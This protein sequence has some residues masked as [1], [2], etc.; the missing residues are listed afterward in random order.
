MKRVR[1]LYQL[2]TDYIKKC[3]DDHVGAFGAMCSF[4]VI[5]SVFP[6]MIFLL[7][8]TRFLPYSKEDIVRILVNAISFD[9]HLVRRIVNEIY[10]KVGT[11]ISLISILSALWAASSGVYAILLGLNSVFDI[12]ETRN[13]FV[14]RLVSMFYTVIV[15]VLMA[16][17]LVFW[18]FGNAL[19]KYICDKWPFLESM[20]GHILHK[21]LMLTV[22]ILIFLFMMIYQFVPN[23]QSRF[24]QQFPGAVI[25][26]IGWVAVSWFY[27]AF[28]DN[29]K[30]FNYIYGSMAGIMLLFLWLYICMSMV[31]YGA[32][33]NYFFENKKNYHKLVRILRPNWDQQ[34]RRREQEI[35]KTETLSGKTNSEEFL[36][37]LERRVEENKKK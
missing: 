29:M 25:A 32:E 36:K 35:Q 15:V 24:I 10:G 28:V 5:L 26:T 12:D 6:I 33:V 18:V 8:L 22:V 21:R 13:Y 37:M 14:L 11:T 27:G 34:R 30:Y 1:N 20:A 16:V 4:F 2:F 17:M 23:R 3:N 19:Y 31:F 7:N 9:E